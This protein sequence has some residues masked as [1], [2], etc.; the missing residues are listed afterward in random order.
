MTELAIRALSKRFGNTVAVNTLDLEIGDHE[1]ISLLGPSG[2]GKT[3]TLRC[4]AGFEIPT[5]GQILFD[6]TDVVALE[7]DKRNIGM[8]FQNY[9]LFPH[10]TVDQNLAFGLEMRRTP[11]AEIKQRIAQ[12]LETVQLGG[13]GERYP[14][15]LSGGQQ[16]RVALARA[17]VIEP[18][19]L[20]LD[21]PLANLD[22]KLREEMRFFIRNLQKRVGITTVYVTHDQ[23]EAMVISDRIVVMF[24]GR[25]HQ[26]GNP[27]EIYT[28]P[29]SREVADFIGLSNF[30]KATVHGPHSDGHYLLDSALG[31]LCCAY[32]DQLAEGES[33]TVIARPEAIEL[34][35]TAPNDNNQP[36]HNSFPGK[37]SER[38]FLG[39]F[40]G[41]RIACADNQLIQVQAQPWTEIAVGQDTWCSF[42]ADK[43]WLIRGPNRL[44]TASKPAQSKKSFRFALLLPTMG[45]F[46]AFLLLPYLNMIVM[47]LRNPSTRQVF[48][49]GFTLN[50]YLEALFDEDWYY[51]E[52]LFDTMVFGI[53]TTAICLLIAYPVAYHLARTQSRFKGLLYAF[54]LSPLLVGVVVRCYGWIIILANQD[55]LI[56]TTLRN[57]GLIETYIPLMYNHLGVGIGLVHIFLPFMI[58]PLLGAIQSIDPALEEAARSLGASRLKVMRRIVFPLSLPGVQAGTVL[59]F[60]LTISSYVI[61]ILLGGMNVMIMPTLVVQQLLDA[62]LWPFG[63][64]LA[65]ILSIAGALVV[66][67]YFKFTARFMKGIS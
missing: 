8:V 41:Y 64:A 10:M 19:I 31:Q 44:M 12:V 50:N 32:D 49:P 46:T 42:D 30:I 39:N 65:F 52:I 14:R 13:L 45:L 37:V 11:A 20:L 58:L 35:T 2:C 15:Q 36:T 66:Y 33:V 51:L 38:F 3:T 18:S 54:V 27:Q 28:R 25:I 60:V 29:A 62:M 59:V 55:G 48:A 9:A 24:D 57:N 17:L 43:A 40:S 7:P 16:Q 63:A 4:I 61:P 47:S 22:A 21:E 34:S 26:V 53:V 1:L 6:R 67:F 23:A 5:S 56:N